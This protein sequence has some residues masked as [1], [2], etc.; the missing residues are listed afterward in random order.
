MIIRSSC[1][2][3]GGANKDEDG[4]GSLEE[5]IFLHQSENT[6]LNYASLLSN[7]ERV[8]L[9][10]HDRIIETADGSIEA[11]RTSRGRLSMCT[12]IWVVSQ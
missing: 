11:C 4:M 1:G 5:D 8:F 6:M 12:A 10:E 9:L 2:M 3:L 7:I